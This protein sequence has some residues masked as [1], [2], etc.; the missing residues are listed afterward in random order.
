MFDVVVPRG[1]LVFER[2]VGSLGRV[3]EE[4]ADGSSW[5]RSLRT[6]AV[7]PRYLEGLVGPGRGKTMRGIARREGL[8]EDR[9]Q[10]FVTESSWEWE[11]AQKQLNERVPARIA[12]PE[13]ALVVDEVA[14]VKHGRRSVGVARQYAGVTGRLEDCQVG[15][16]VVLAVPGRRW[17]SSRQVTYPLGMELYLPRAWC[18]DT[19]ARARVGVPPD[20]TFQ[21]KPEIA[22]RL[23]S[24]TRKA[25]VPHCVVLADAG[26]GQNGAFRKQLRTWGEP[27]QVGINPTKMRFIPEHTPLTHPEPPQSSG[28]RPRKYPRYPETVP[29]KTPLQLSKETTWEPIT[30]GHDPDNNPLTGEFARMR[31]RHVTRPKKQRTAT[32]ETAWLLLERTQTAS[33]KPAIHAYLCWGVDDWPL[34]KMARYAH[35]RWPIEQ[36]HRN[37]KQELALDQFEGRTWKGWHHHTTMVLL[38]HALL[39]TLQAEYHH[40]PPIRQIIRALAL[41]RATQL[42]IAHGIPRPQ[43]HQIATDYIRGFTDWT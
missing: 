42:T 8:P 41:E 23:L 18:E 15:V 24:R 10:R 13:G 38:A 43:A 28:G 34:Q 6:R 30:W 2:F 19:Q 4:R 39:S 37:A 35:Q 27:Y 36:F 14:L 20:V 7:A 33:G 29:A 3:F 17:K 26:Y 21:T 22:L 40:P 1:R 9:V 31:V 5:A 25:G 11:G 12:S 32:S 16:D